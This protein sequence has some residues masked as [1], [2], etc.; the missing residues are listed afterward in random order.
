[1]ALDLQFHRERDLRKNLE[2]AMGVRMVGVVLIVLGVIGLLYGGIQWTK[3]DK[4]VDLGPVEV[5]KEKHE[6]VPIP[7]IAG[8]VCLVAGVAIVTTTKRA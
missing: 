1:M 8:V 3:R 2:A 5:T 7:P 6:S 4:I